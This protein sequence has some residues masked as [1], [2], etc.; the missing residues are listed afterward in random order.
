[1]TSI[2]FVL[3][4]KELV[5]LHFYV[6]FLTS[7]C[8]ISYLFLP[9]INKVYNNDDDNSNNNN[10]YNNNNNN[11]N[12]NNDK[13]CNNFEQIIQNGLVS[14]LSAIFHTFTNSGCLIAIFL[15]SLS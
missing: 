3:Y 14:K 1:M 6:L 4:I 2:Y 13:N 8:I 11:N 5:N 10:S 12:N 15:V 7:I 9:R